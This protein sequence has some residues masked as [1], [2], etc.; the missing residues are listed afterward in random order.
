MSVS[1][2]KNEIPEK[3]LLELHAAC[4]G[5]QL[6]KACRRLLERCFSHHFVAIG[7]SFRGDEPMTIKRAKPAPERS[8]EWWARN[9]AAHPLMDI[10]IRKPYPKIIRITDQIPPDEIRVHAY[11]KEFIEP[12]GW[13]YS[14][15]VFPR[16]GD[17]LMGL[18]SVNRREDQ[19][20][21]TPEEM[22]LFDQLYPHFQ[23]A[24]KR[25][26][27]IQNDYASRF[28]MATML[29]RIP[30]AVAIVSHVGEINFINDAA[31]R[32]CLEWNENGDTE[33]SETP[34]N[35]STATL[36]DLVRDRC[37]EL[38]AEAEALTA[39][40]APANLE[41]HSVRSESNPD[42]T[43][44]IEYLSARHEPFSKAAF[45][46]RFE[47]QA[48][49]TGNLA[50][51]VF[52]RY[53]KLTTA[54]KIVTEQALEGLTNREIA[55]KLGKSVST[56]KNQLESVFRKMAIHKRHELIALAPLLTAALEEIDS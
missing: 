36:P 38:V 54:E 33:K 13:F 17:R 51:E 47:R 35:L 19:G 26:S 43:A 15:G 49:D 53:C 41:P 46:V 6:W 23:T 20:D 31:R 37:L 21:F 52:N 50:T 40:N 4:D 24:F 56:V 28:S 3:L 55:E 2:P 32:A 34:Y 14:V 25:V 30:L 11:Y 42:Y 22:A 18:L 1:R 12:E 10:L 45:L 48:N 27:E 8:P 7:Y 44:A 5:T 9:M 16:D 29:S 39:L